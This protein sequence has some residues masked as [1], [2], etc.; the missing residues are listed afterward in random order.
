MAQ[1]PGNLKVTNQNIAIFAS[2]SGSNAEA[3]F[4]YFGGNK[5]INICLLL[6]NNKHA[7]AIQRA[8]KFG[9]PSVTFN[10]HEF[11]ETDGVLNI[12]KKHDISFIV[13][14]GFLWKIPLNLIG[15]YHRRMVNIHPALLPKFGGKGM[16]GMYVHRAV[17]EAGEKESGIT[18]HYV[19]ENYDEG[20]IIF[21]EKCDVASSDSPEMVARNVQKLEH[22]F[23]PE[24][25]EK[26]LSALK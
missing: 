2:G 13:L 18:I 4:K 22:K 11:Y 12:L 26:C 5:N 17:V 15:S 8:E 10:R 7:F 24:V 9:I 20:E 19:T 23:Y 25:V 6:T 1:K 21:Q 16:Y 3:F 14:A